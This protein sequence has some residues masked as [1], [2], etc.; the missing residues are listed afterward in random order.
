MFL[1]RGCHRYLQSA[2]FSPSASAR[3][4]GRCRDC[5]GLDNIAR[6]RDDFSCYKN[7]LRRLRADEQRLNAEAKIPFL[8]QVE[9]VRYLVEVVWAS[10][11]AL[12]AS[13]DLYNL[14]FVRWERQRD[15]SPW[16]CILLSKEET[17]AHLEV[18]DVHKVNMSAFIH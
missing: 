2:D 6:S 13:S 5:T 3:L 10:R 18:E 4:S 9:D 7:I 15:W 17:S 14:V 8:L 1:C 16:N 12:Q 11:S